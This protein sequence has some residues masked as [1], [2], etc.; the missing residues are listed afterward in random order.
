M[1]AS[2]TSET[3]LIKLRVLGGVLTDLQPLLFGK[4]AAVLFLHIKD[5][6]LLMNPMSFWFK[7][8]IEADTKIGYQMVVIEK[9]SVKSKAP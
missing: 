6:S 8:L 1:T 2:P 9:F 7:G 3:P 4:G 5:N